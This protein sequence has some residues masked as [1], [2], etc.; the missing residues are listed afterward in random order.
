MAD[1][2]ATHNI[3]ILWTFENKKSMVLCL[4]EN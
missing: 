4:C 2:I 3:L 1:N